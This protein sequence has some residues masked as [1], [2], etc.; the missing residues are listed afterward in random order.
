MIKCRKIQKHEKPKESK[1]KCKDASKWTVAMSIILTSVS[2][3]DI[4]V[5]TKPKL[6]L[7]DKCLDC[8]G[9]GIQM[10]I[11]FPQGDTLSEKRQAAHDLVDRCFDDGINMWKH[12]GFNIEQENRR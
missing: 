2:R 4:R 1:L 6:R 8:G 12:F 11:F 9:K 5:H 3:K 7:G 10:E